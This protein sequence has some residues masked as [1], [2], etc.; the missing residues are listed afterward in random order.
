MPSGTTRICLSMIVR[1][2]AAVIERCLA[3]AS[4]LVDA[5]V[6]V[7]T[8]SSDLTVGLAR[9][10]LSARG[11][12]WSILHQRW[13]NFGVNRQAALVEARTFVCGL[14]W[15]LDRTFW[16]LLDADLELS[17]GPDFDR[18]SLMADAISL[19]HES[20][21]LSYWSLRLAR[22][23]LDWRLEGPTHER[24][25]CDARCTSGRL[26]SL[27]IR[28]HGDGGA[29]ADKIPRD[30]R[31]LGAY[32]DDHPD[33]P[34][35]L[36]YLA[37]SYRAAG[38]P[39]KATALYRR[40]IAVGDASEEAWYAKYRLGRLLAD[41]GRAEAA[42]DVLVET[43]QADR[44][45]AEPLYELARL[46][47]R[48]GE[49]D[50]AA[51]WASKGRR[52]PLP[53]GRTLVHLDV[54]DHKLDL[55]LAL[56][57]PK[58]AFHD[59][60]FEACERL[61]L[62]RGT[63]E[64]VRGEARCAALSYAAPLAG[65]E[66]LPLHP[67]LDERYRPCNPSIVG[68]ANG[69]LVNCRAVNYRQRRLRYRSLDEDGV[70]RTTNVLMTLDRSFQLVEEH[71]LT[72]DEPPARRTPVRGFED[73]RLFTLDGD[74]MML[75]TTTDRHPSGRMHQSI[76]R[77]DTAG[78]IVSHLPLVGPFDDRV[79]KNWLPYVDRGEPDRLRAIYG[80]DPITVLRLDPRRGSYEAALTVDLP[81]DARCWRGSAG[82]LWWPTAGSR[83]VVLVHD[84]VRRQGPDGVWERVYLHR[85]IELDASWRLTR[86]SKPFVF[87]H[88]GVEFACGMVKSC[89]G[90]VLITI[91][92]EDHDAYI[93]RIPAARFDAMLGENTDLLASLRARDIDR[94]TA[95]C[96]P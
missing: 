32:L 96:R 47:R 40:R 80:Y 14:D 91:G 9:G 20:A 95:A 83:R 21:T 84:A 10:V 44:A 68:T 88:H 17:I 94:E 52:L 28:D 61:V 86:L 69:Y 59:E 45:R 16:L 1:N 49:H 87:A 55:E 50:M 48:A 37:Q 7:D 25:V 90:D 85:I 93:C 3:A 5:A 8:G 54:Y 77:L 6:I 81:V 12:P 72:S 74:L 67:R 39:V 38:D 64:P 43:Y 4:P 51:R 24:Y 82:P 22:A 63:P 23:S 58:T 46:H 29:K 56:A 65:C 35:A 11:R 41:H 53:L 26:A 66:F 92:I 2:E 73:V 60:G 62:R 79:Q 31:L 18:D 34:R 42:A 76:C 70:Y 13:Q 15:P 89:E 30:I 27:S 71:P 57:A 33:D 75:C 36:F 19:R 78:H